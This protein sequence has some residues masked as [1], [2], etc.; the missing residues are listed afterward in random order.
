MAPSDR[1]YTTSCQSTIVT[2]ATVSF[3]SYLTLNNITPGNLGRHNP[4]LSEVALFDKSHTN[5][6]W[7]SIVTMALTCIVSELKQDIGR[8]SQLYFY[9][10]C[11]RRPR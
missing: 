5:S 2:I 7:R 4:R 11:I 3:S 9:P 1:S 10:T 6:Y 8:K